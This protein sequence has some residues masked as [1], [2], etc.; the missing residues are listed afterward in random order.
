MAFSNGK[1]GS[2]FISAK[3]KRL[4]HSYFKKIGKIRLFSVLT[5]SVLIY[6]LINDSVTNGISIVID[7]EYP[8]YEKFISNK[9]RELLSEHGI[10]Y[11]YRFYTGQIGK[12]S[13]AHI[14]AYKNYINIRNAHITKQTA[15]DIIE[16]LKQNKKPG[17]T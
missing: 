11:N 17:D 10:S 1:S 8:G 5:F 2:I 12:K 16:I 9:I 6:L 7:R 15:N 3:E 13:R 14:I 4:L